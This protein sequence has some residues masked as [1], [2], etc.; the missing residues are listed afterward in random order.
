[1]QKSGD[2]NGKIV[3]FV[4]KRKDKNS[5]DESHRFC[6]YVCNFRERQNE[7]NILLVSSLKTLDG[8][9]K[10]EINERKIPVFELTIKKGIVQQERIFPQL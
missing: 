10:E 4:M 2:T 3:V 6:Q 5:P 7:I 1:M 8:F 9:F